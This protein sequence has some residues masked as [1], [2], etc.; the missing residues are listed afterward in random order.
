MLFPERDIADDFWAFVR[1]LAIDPRVG[2][3][4]PRS[5]GHPDPKRTNSQTLD[6]LE[7]ERYERS[8]RLAGPH[9][10]K[11]IGP[12]GTDAEIWQIYWPEQR[13]PWGYR[14]LQE[15]LTAFLIDSA[16][17]DR[18]TFSLD[19]W[20]CTVPV[21]VAD[22]I[23]NPDLLRVILRDVAMLRSGEEDLD[24]PEGQREY[25]MT[26][27]DDWSCLRAETFDHIVATYA[28]KG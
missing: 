15:A 17:L 14:T 26:I 19:I 21:I 4:E 28:G 2:T 6:Q 18:L 24:D 13:M 16:A 8:V 12:P 22:A 23:R 3:E 7:E 5:P 9:A 10:F 11:K 27:S 25:T 1:D 20:R